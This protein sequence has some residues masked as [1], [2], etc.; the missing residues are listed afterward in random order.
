[1]KN[2]YIIGGSGT[3]KT[4]LAKNIENW[5]KTKFKRIIQH[6]TRKR[7]DCEQ[8]GI[9]Y[10]FITHEKWKEGFDKKELFEFIRYQFGAGKEYG[11]FFSDLD[12]TRWNVLVMSIEGL[13]TG[14]KNS[15][16][17][18][19]TLIL[20]IIAD[21]DPDIRREERDYMME[22]NF[23]ISILRTIFE[24]YKDDFVFSNTNKPVYVEIKLS[25]L[26]EIRNSGEEFLDFL[27]NYLD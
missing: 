7:R 5:D 1:M 2:I 27:E 8:E 6:T 14:L 13:L 26:K 21:D 3:G 15:T 23:N 20:H 9:D 17:K 25:K 10:N 16:K 19:K 4:T 24:D 22:Q 18:D 11:C 12:E